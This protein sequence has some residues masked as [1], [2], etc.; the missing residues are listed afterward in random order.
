M[1]LGAKHVSNPGS[2]IKKCKP[3]FIHD[4]VSRPQRLR[5]H[6]LMCL[7]LWFD[8]LQAAYGQRGPAARAL[9]QRPP[10]QRCH[11]PLTWVLLPVLCFVL[12]KYID[13]VSLVCLQVMD[14]AANDTQALEEENDHLHDRCNALLVRAITCMIAAMPCWSVQSPA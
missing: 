3:H 13:P 7:R 12:V 1:L 6:V 5:A 8:V 9:G 2:V 14:E 10:Y 11:A 4:L